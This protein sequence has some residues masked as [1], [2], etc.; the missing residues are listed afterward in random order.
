MNSYER[1]RRA[2]E[3]REPDVVPVAPYMG[4]YGA[5]LAGAAVDEYCRIL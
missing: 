2:V 3:L 4:N 5:K 1:F